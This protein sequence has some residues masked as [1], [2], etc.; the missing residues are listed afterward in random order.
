M[1]GRGHRVTAV[2]PVPRLLQ[3]TRPIVCRGDFTTPLSQLFILFLFIE[4]NELKNNIYIYI[5]YLLSYV[6]T[7]S[8]EVGPQS[9]GA[10]NL[11]TSVTSVASAL[12]RQTAVSLAPRVTTPADVDIN[13]QT[14]KTP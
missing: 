5:I 8:G 7:F 2:P 3:I 12:L 9:P 11:S 4:S 13:C 1:T 10:A 6:V 14:S